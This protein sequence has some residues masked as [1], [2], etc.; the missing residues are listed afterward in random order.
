[1][2]R[3]VLILSVALSVSRIEPAIAQ[4]GGSV[5]GGGP[6]AGGASGLIWILLIGAVIL[7]VLLLKR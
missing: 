6:G 7:A 1:M 5:M 4:V 3:F 2:Q